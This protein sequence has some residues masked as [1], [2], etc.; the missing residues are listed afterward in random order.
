[1]R[2]LSGVQFKKEDSVNP[3]CIESWKSMTFSHLAQLSQEFN[4]KL[5]ELGRQNVFNH[6]TLNILK[7]SAT[8]IQVLQDWMKHHGFANILHI[9]SNF[10]YDPNSIG[11]S[12]SYQIGENKP[13][14]LPRSLAH[15]L[16]LLC[17]CDK[18]WVSNS[19]IPTPNIGWTSLT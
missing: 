10:Y 14:T 4:V 6:I 15:N 11:I 5:T 13:G 2:H 9:L 8:K 7:L 19:H 17:S 1:M 12:S 3:F 18:E 16:K